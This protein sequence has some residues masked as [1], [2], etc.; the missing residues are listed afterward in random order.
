MK[1]PF[2][3]VL[4]NIGAAL[5]LSLLFCLGSG[6]YNDFFIFFGLIGIFGGLFEIVLGLFLLL[7]DDK[8]FAQGFLLSGGLL[9]LLGFM[10]CSNVSLNLH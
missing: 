9:L 7:L 4:I 8:R 1:L 3:I 5:L 2:K 10:S 6:S